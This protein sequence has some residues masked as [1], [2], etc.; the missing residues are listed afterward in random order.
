MRRP[1]MT[2]RR[3]MV[4]VAFGAERLRRRSRANAFLAACHAGAQA[5]LAEVVRGDDGGRVAFDSPRRWPE[6]K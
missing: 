1:R 4:A 5:P 6:G 3:W 2:T